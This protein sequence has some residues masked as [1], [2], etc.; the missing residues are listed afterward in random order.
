VNDI[1]SSHSKKTI[2][3]HDL[4][5]L[6]IPRNNESAKPRPRRSPR[7]QLFPRARRK[8]VG[9]YSAAS[10]FAARGLRCFCATAFTLCWKLGSCLVRPRLTAG[11]SEC[12][13]VKFYRERPDESRHTG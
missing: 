12:V 4:E 10:I 3:L 6:R 13:G 8:S 2:R 9:K 7:N 5:T 11:L 1:G